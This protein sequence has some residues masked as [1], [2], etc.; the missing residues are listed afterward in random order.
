MVMNFDTLVGI[1]Q[2][3]FGMAQVD[4]RLIFGRVNFDSFFSL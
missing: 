1:T 3:Y 4:R 2:D